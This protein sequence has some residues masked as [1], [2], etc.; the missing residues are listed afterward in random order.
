MIFSKSFFQIFA[1]WLKPKYQFRFLEES[2]KKISKNT[3]YI[4]GDSKNPWVL[5]FKCPC[6]CKDVI[7]LNLLREAEPNWKF[8]ISFQN[9]ISISPSIYRTIGCHSHFHIKDGRVNWAR[10]HKT[11]KKE[12]VWESQ[13]F[14]I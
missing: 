11:D 3:I 1:E 6:G 4:I 5:I 13:N 14:R 12:T 7:H 9:R 10:R 2:P 8:R